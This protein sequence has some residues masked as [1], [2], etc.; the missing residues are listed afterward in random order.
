VPCHLALV[1]AT[2]NASSTPNTEVA[3]SACSSTGRGG[4]GRLSSLGSEGTP[5]DGQLL[6]GPRP[7]RLPGMVLANLLEPEDCLYPWLLS[8][9]D[10]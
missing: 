6:D 2:M 9:A 7:Q 3:R 1:D 4:T 8:R 5:G 10:S